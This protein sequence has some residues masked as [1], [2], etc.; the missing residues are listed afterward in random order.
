MVG[1]SHFSIV[2]QK[3]MAL[4]IAVGVFAV[5]SVAMACVT[6]AGSGDLAF[7]AFNMFEMCVGM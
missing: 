4:N 1:C 5:T 7:T 2:I 3:E 6:F